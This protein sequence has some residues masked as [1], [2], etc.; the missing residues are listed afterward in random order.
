MDQQLTMPEVVDFIERVG[1]ALDWSTRYMDL[2][3][4]AAGAVFRAEELDEQTDAVPI[5]EAVIDNQI[6]RLTEDMALRGRSPNTGA[7]YVGT[8]KRVSTIAEG[9]LPLR[10]TPKEEYFW[11]TIDQYRDT[12]PTRRTRDRNDSLH[13]GDGTDVWRR[14]EVPLDD[15]VAVVSLPRKLS[16]AEAYRIVVAVMATG[17]VEAS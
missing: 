9:W 12:R 5:G 16:Q 2:A 15:G 3:A 1:D 11:E 4:T 14:I 7:V 17:A 6:A 10:G 8:W 13:T